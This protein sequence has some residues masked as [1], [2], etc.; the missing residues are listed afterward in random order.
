MIV[1]GNATARV[2]IAILIRIRTGL[3]LQLDIG[4]A[5]SLSQS[6]GSVASSARGGKL[7]VV[8]GP[9]VKK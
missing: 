6:V 2:D 7:P 4:P 8:A 1:H 3:L 5:R 9:I